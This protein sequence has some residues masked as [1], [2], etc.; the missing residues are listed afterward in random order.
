MKGTTYW[1]CSHRSK[2][3]NVLLHVLRKLFQ[4]HEQGNSISTSV[5]ELG[6]RL[7]TII[8][9]GVEANNAVMRRN[10]T[11]YVILI[12]ELPPCLRQKTAVC[13]FWCEITLW[14]TNRVLSHFVFH[15][16]RS[17]H[18]RNIKL[19]KSPSMSRWIVHAPACKK[20]LDVSYQ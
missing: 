14:L 19:S 5:P 18:F 2:C 9:E 12:L 15:W 10:T 17:M 7:G 1:R 16:A 20:D 8:E 11:Q 3:F 13:I 4:Q 6:V